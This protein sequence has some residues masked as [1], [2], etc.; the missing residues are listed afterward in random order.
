[1]P[2][3][4]GGPMFDGT[5][6]IVL[7]GDYNLNYYPDRNNPQ[8]IAEG[9][10]PYFYWVPTRIRLAQKMNGDFIFR[11]TH[12]EGV[13]SSDTT[14]GVQG[15]QE[16]AGGIL[17]FSATAAPPAAVLKEAETQLQ[18]R[19]RSSGHP[20]WR[21]GNIKPNF[22][23]VP[24]LSCTTFVS[25][26][27][28]NSVTDRSVPVQI[29]PKSR[30]APPQITAVPLS[31]IEP[32]S[33]RSVPVAK[34]SRDASNLSNSMY[35]VVQG[36]GPGNINLA[37]ENAYSALLDPISSGIL[38]TSFHGGTSNITVSQD[39]KL[40]FWSPKVKLDIVGDWQRI[41]DHFSV[42]GHAGGLFWSADVQAEFNNMQTNGT[43][44]VKFDV[45][46]TMPGGEQ[47][48]EQLQKRADMV[49]QKFEEAAK[50]MIFDPPPPD[51]KAAQAS[52]GILGF[53]GGLAL[54]AR[55]DYTGLHLE[56]HE[57]DWLTFALPTRISGALEGLADEIQAHPEAEKKY[58]TKFF[59]D[60]WDR[61]V[62]KIFKPVVN[63]PDPARKWIGEPVAFLSAQVG[64]P[65]TSGELQW[66][67]HVFQP[68]DPVDAN[69]TPAMAQ[70]S[71]SDVSNPPQG[72]APDKTYIKRQVH[73]AEPPSE[74]E[75]P[76][77][78]C[79]VE[80]NVVDLDPGELGTLTNDITLEVRADS[81]GKLDVGPIGLSVELENSKQVVEVSFQALGK[82]DAGSDRPITKFNWLYPDQG[83]SRYWTIFTGQLSF[84]SKFRY[85][86][87]VIVKGTLFSK[88]MEWLGPWEETGGNGPITITV[89]TAD[90]PNVTR[91]SLIPT[92]KPA[93]TN[94]N[95]APAGNGKGT[96]PPATAGK[97][98]G[99]PPPATRVTRS[100]E[101]HLTNS[102]PELE[103]VSGWST[104]PPSD[105]T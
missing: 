105:R 3:I 95:A 66:Q 29:P 82:T 89:P 46:E 80:K 35:M 2:T 41:Y 24:T 27:A 42:A 22:S 5:N 88:G 1:M 52:G 14:I 103:L 8:L 6:T 44:T 85:Q 100:V 50:K 55:H 70:K 54:K 98:A 63:Y 72:W 84:V 21:L 23:P 53:G 79:F 81:V 99:T 32:V 28:L 101:G 76:F 102:A 19:V 40:R 83:E 16:L 64:Y 92:K 11:H 15:T 96:P 34:A 51:V 38:W 25:N 65:N 86:V 48:K 93:A 75:Y 31:E 74:M 10:A 17:T 7:V 30:N 13:L 71:L 58:F 90:D 67:G 12:Y 91:R 4:A 9:Q 69:W 37:G 43:I 61:K 57:E 56:Y 18:E 87:R 97:G 78:R 60:D 20:F 68:T 36:Q 39:V 77:I 59:L 45:D 49:Y 73:F 94:G 62:T 47:L 33:R 104:H 26:V